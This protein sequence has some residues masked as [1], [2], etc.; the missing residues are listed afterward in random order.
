MGMVDNLAWAVYVDSNSCEGS[1]KATSWTAVR[2]EFPPQ[3][4]RGLSVPSL[5]RRDPWVERHMVSAHFS[6]VSALASPCIH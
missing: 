5:C 3:I 1:T 6:C 2:P 4:V